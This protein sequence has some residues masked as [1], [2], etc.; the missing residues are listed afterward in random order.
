[1]SPNFQEINQLAPN[2]VDKVFPIPLPSYEGLPDGPHDG[3]FRHGATMDIDS[4]AR[5]SIPKLSIEYKL[6][7]PNNIRLCIKIQNCGYWV[8]GLEFKIKFSNGEVILLQSLR[9]DD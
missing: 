8:S 7:P 1:M 2:D 9:T 3:K 4:N 6:E 5:G